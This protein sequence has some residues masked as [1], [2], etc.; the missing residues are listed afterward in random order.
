MKKVSDIAFLII[1]LVMSSTVHSQGGCATDLLGKAFCAPAGGSAVSTLKGVACA[2]GKCV[3]DNLGYVKCSSELGG[4]V[5]QDNLGR[6]FC[7][8]NCINPSKEYC[9]EMKQDK[10]K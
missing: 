9:V 5:T 2:P 6:V 10:T 8:G 4:G 1:V 3:A 7:V